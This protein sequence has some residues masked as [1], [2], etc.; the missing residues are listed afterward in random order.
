[1]TRFDK[2]RLMSGKYAGRVGYFCGWTDSHPL[3]SERRAKIRVQTG[4]GFRTL[5]VNESNF[6]RQVIIRQGIAMPAKVV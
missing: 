5:L 1:M 3:S 6:K 2:V 4:H